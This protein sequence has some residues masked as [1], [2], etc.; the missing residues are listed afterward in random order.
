M[1]RPVLLL[2]TRATISRFLKVGKMLKILKQ[3]PLRLI[4]VKFPDL[5][6][7]DIYAC[8]AKGPQQ[9]KSFLRQ[10]SHVYVT[11]PLLKLAILFFYEK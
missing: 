4:Q 8:S 5:N 6:H 1:E 10:H 3:L 11:I 9:R 2:T 7:H